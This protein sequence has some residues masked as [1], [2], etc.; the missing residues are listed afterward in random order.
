MVAST[1]E[2]FGARKE[3]VPVFSFMALELPSMTKLRNQARQVSAD[4]AASSIR[5]VR[6][7][8]EARRS[9]LNCVLVTTVS[10]SLPSQALL[11]RER[12]N[13]GD[14]GA[15]EASDIEPEIR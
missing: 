15:V 12:I 3:S 11:H 14:L 6:K 8:E 7:F 5:K 1:V 2:R 9:G 4:V 13:L 10:K